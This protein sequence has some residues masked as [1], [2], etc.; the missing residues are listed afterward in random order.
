MH[1]ITE[2]KPLHT[3]IFEKT[4]QVEELQTLLEMKSKELESLQERKS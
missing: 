2:V 3:E 4:S 1:V